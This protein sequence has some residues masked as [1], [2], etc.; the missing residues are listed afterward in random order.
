MDQHLDRRT[1][2][3][4]RSVGIRENI[5][6]NVVMTLKTITVANGY[7]NDIGLVSR[8]VFNWTKVQPKDFPAVF[9]GW[10]PE[11]KDA[12]GL[13]GQHILADLT[14]TISGVVWAENDLETKLNTFIS[15]VEKAMCA[16]TDRGDYAEYT[17]PLT[18]RIMRT[19]LVTFVL[20]DFSFRIVYQY[21]YG[22]P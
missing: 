12:T 18:I 3:E 21:L 13:Q 16:D 10:T 2:K 15:D 20:F 5:L 14:V 11:D 17:E 4:D 8:D 1:E 7:E 19:E 9:V 6:N 22:S